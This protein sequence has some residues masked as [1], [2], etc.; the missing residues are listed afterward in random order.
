LLICIGLHSTAAAAIVPSSV[1][2]LQLWLDAQDINGDGSAFAGASVGSWQDKSGNNN[3][4]I[5]IVLGN[6]PAYIA[7]GGPEFG[8]FPIVRFDGANDSLTL[9]TGFM[10]NEAAFT[11][12]ILHKTPFD[13]NEAIFGPSGAFLTG[14]EMLTGNIGGQPSLWR[15]NGTP[16]TGTG[17]WDDDIVS[18]S[19]IAADNASTQAYKNGTA[20]P[21]LDASGI[22]PL[23][24]NGI[25][26]IGSYFVGFNSAPDV[27]E[28]LIYN[29]KLTD[30]ERHGVEAYLD[31]KW[32]NP[33]VAAVPEPASLVVWGGMALIAAGG[34]S[35]RRRMKR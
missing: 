33:P 27:A 15:L 34:V 21:M 19:T 18:L 7:D 8:N 25:Y 2:G 11:M 22:A 9:P 14:I 4:A 13:S 16:K 17:A 3:D 31:E 26:T 1:S 30:A 5:Q 12:I 32:L 35:R 10:F 23:N 24:F 29:R 20:S 6:R 28:L